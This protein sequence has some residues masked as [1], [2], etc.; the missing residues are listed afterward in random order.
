MQGNQPSH[1][2]QIP[3]L[4]ALLVFVCVAVLSLTA[5]VLAYKCFFFEIL[6]ILSMKYLLVQCFD[7]IQIAF[8]GHK[9]CKFASRNLAFVQAYKCFFFKI[10]SILPMKYLL[11]QCFDVIQIAFTGH[12]FCK[13]AFRNLAFCISK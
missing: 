9:F 5:F 13:F 6:S 4:V 7:V 10:L 11:V 8:T 2:V 1:A 3:I 12:K